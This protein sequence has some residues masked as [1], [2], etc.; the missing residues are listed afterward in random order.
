MEDCINNLSIADLKAAYDFT[1]IDL[2]E[3]QE[4]AGEITL[5]KIPCYPEIME[6]KEKLFNE[7][8]NR[9]RSLV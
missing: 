6:T 7:L 4:T 3:L 9:T 5:S 2:K 8:L 1:V